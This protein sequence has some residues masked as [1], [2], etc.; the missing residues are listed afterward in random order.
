MSTSRKCGR[1]SC[2]TADSSL[3]KLSSEGTCWR[4]WRRA[5]PINTRHAD[6]AAARGSKLKISSAS[7][8]EILANLLTPI[9]LILSD[10]TPNESAERPLTS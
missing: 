10:S 6:R 1:R 9:R 8:P 5:D 4:D 3:N 2:T 7:L